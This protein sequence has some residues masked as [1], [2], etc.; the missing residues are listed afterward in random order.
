MNICYSLSNEYLKS[1]GPVAGPLHSSSFANQ[2][3]K[4]MRIAIVLL[5]LAASAVSVFAADLDTSKLPASAKR[6]IDFV[7]D[8]QPIL[9]KNCYSC[10]GPDKQEKDLRWDLLSSALKGGTTGP[11]I[12]SGKSAESRM[13]HL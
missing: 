10:H 3:G 5:G 6:Q 8:I 7:R 4:I 2:T 12:I 11:A 1:G 13:I 9:S